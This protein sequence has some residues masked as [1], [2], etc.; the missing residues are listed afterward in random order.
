M[1]L[2]IRST[3]VIALIACNTAFAQGV[4]FSTVTPLPKSVAVISGFPLTIPDQHLDSYGINPANNTGGWGDVMANVTSALEFKK[5]YPQMTV[6]LVVTLNDQDIRLNVNKTRSIVQKSLTGKNGEIVL[7]PDLKTVQVYRGVE[8][9]F[10]DL[11][12]RLYGVAADERSV[13]DQNLIEKATQH[14]PSSEVGMQFSANNFPIAPQIAKIKEMYLGFNEYNED[15]KNFQYVLLK[16]S[17]IWIKMNAGPLSLG[18]YGFNQNNREQNKKII[19]SYIDRI[20]L[21]RINFPQAELAFAYAGDSALIE[22]YVAAVK[23][24]ASQSDAPF[25]V[26]VKGDGPIQKNRNLTLIPLGPHPQELAHALIAESTYSPLVTGDG[27]LSSALSSASRSG[28]RAKSFVYEMVIWK[29]TFMSSLMIKIFGRG[30]AANKGLSLTFAPLE[31]S[32]DLKERN[33]RVQDIASALQNEELHAKIS[34]FIS[35]NKNQLDLVDNTVNV[36]QVKKV[37][38]NLKKTSGHGAEEY[39]QWLLKLTQKTQASEDWIRVLQSQIKDTSVQRDSN[40][41]KDVLFSMATLWSLNIEIPEDILKKAANDWN[42]VMV[43]RKTEKIFFLREVVL[44]ILEQVSTLPIA[45]EQLSHISGINSE[46]ART[47]AD[48]ETDFHDRFKRSLNNSCK[49]L[50]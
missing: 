45:Q 11:P 19:N 31:D 21:A 7:N 48:Y 50:F 44:N 23:K 17:P 8:I 9:Y 5:R 24:L 40:R 13:S 16:E 6:R 34:N 35:R 47:L 22:D 33:Q 15:P 30:E 28:K 37:F 49:S 12:G 27:S 10:V 41:L 4:G 43:K 29:D 18:V 32:T 38:S 25:F 20:G 46:F 14:I 2:L 26:F 39:T 36:F 3:I 1:S 42:L